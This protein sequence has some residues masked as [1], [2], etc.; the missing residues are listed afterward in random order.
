MISASV[1]AAIIGLVSAIVSGSFAVAE[2]NKENDTVRELA[3]TERAKSAN[4]SRASII[5]GMN[6]TTIAFGVITA[7][8][9]IIFLLKK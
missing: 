1:V 7:L 3:R 9:I 8:I 4:E 2:K 5:E 6:M